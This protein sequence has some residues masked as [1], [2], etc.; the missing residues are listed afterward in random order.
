MLQMG[1]VYYCYVLCKIVTEISSKL[2]LSV[3]VCRTMYERIKRIKEEE[4]SS[5]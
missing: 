5:F 2:F 1:F 4:F 3:N